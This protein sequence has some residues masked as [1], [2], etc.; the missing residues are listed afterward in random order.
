MDQL[1]EKI[2]QLLS[3]HAGLIDGMTEHAMGRYVRQLENFNRQLDNFKRGML[4]Q[5][6]DMESKSAK[7][8]NKIEKSNYVLG[9]LEKDIEK[10]KDLIERLNNDFEENRQVERKKI[11]EELRK[12]RKDA[13]EGMLTEF[14]EVAIAERDVETIIDMIH[15]IYR[16]R[17]MDAAVRAKFIKLVNEVI[18]DKMDIKEKEK[19]AANSNELGSVTTE[20]NEKFDVLETAANEMKKRVQFMRNLHQTKIRQEKEKQERREQ[21]E[22]RKANFLFQP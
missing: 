14:K 19:F 1:L 9:K 18:G 11:E 20:I 22:K 15:Q 3:G 16:F 8:E 7:L 6:H 4:E 17:D 2:N 5:M 12:F 21:E 10:R 13:A